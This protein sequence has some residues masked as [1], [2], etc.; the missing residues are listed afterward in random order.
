MTL[1]P[2]MRLTLIAVLLFVMVSGFAHGADRAEG[3]VRSGGEEKS[4]PKSE[5]PHAVPENDETTGQARNSSEAEKGAKSADQP[6]KPWSEKGMGD[7]DVPWERMVIGLFF[8]IILVCVGVYLLKKFGGARFG[9]GRYMSVLETVPLSG[10]QNLSLVKIGDRIILLATDKEHVEKVAEFDA[11]DLPEPK[12]GDAASEGR[13]E[14]I[15]QGFMK[16]QG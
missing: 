3:S 5:Q 6:S 9:H 1:R 14:G 4:A 7:V 16:G 15:L 8:V 12:E 10:Q 2:T 13:F 11:D